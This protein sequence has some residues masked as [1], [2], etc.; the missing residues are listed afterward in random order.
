MRQFILLNIA[1]FEEI[2]ATFGDADF[3]MGMK[4][5]SQELHPGKVNR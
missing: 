5:F 2:R 1:Q 3:F 4:L